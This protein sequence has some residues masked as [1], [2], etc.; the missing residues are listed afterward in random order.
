MHVGKKSESPMF[1][2]PSANVEVFSIS[3]MQFFLCKNCCPTFFLQQYINFCET[4]I[5]MTEI[6]TTKMNAPKTFFC[7]KIIFCHKVIFSMKTFDAKK[8]VIIFSLAIICCH[9]FG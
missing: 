2:L 3:S 8:M 9:T 5:S 7:Q 1:V 4:N 6:L